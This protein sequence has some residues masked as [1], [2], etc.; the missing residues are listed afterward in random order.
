MTNANTERLEVLMVN[1]KSEDHTELME[2]AIREFFYRHG[3]VIDRRGVVDIDS[4]EVLFTPRLLSVE[5]IRWGFTEI[6]RRLSV[7]VSHD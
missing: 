4:D 1:P 7:Q 3:L 5:A 2:L 6:E